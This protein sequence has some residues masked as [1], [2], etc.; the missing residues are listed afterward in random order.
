MALQYGPD[1]TRIA[2]E[3]LRGWCAVCG[4]VRRERRVQFLVATVNR[5]TANRLIG[6][7]LPT[8]DLRRTQPTDVRYVLGLTR[9]FFR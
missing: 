7:S 8:V 9:G 2:D 3:L 6:V 4:G 5:A 1:D